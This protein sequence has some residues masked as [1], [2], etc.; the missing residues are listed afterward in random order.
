MGQAALFVGEPDE[1]VEE[2]RR[3]LREQ[4]RVQAQ[5]QPPRLVEPDRKQIELR[6]HDLDSLLP[7]AHRARSV[8]AVVERLDVRRFYE[9][10][11]ARGSKEVTG[12]VER[13]AETVQQISKA[14]NEQ[15]RG[16]EQIMRSTERMKTLSQQ[17]ELSSQEQSK[18]SK[19]ISTSI[20]HINEMV[21]QLHQAQSEQ[22][23]GS[24]QLLAAVEQLRSAQFRQIEILERA[25]PR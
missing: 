19:Q 18:G 23:R 16:S 12:S 11:K 25:R 10:I 6:P 3:A 14:T 17:V 22:A 9:P 4:R 21:R 8:W 13:I 15:A 5:S 2:R 20:E 7:L 1:V 24:E